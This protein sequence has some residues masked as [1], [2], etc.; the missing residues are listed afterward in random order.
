MGD[1]DAATPLPLVDTA[2][3]APFLPSSF[4]SPNIQLPI[5]KLE[6]HNYLDW[7]W[8]MKLILR[9][10]GKMGYINGSIQAPLPTEQGYP[11]WDSENSLVMAWLLFSMKPEI[12]RRFMGKKTAKDIWDSVAHIFD[13]VGDS[14]KVSFFF[15]FVLLFS[16]SSSS[17]SHQ[18]IINSTSEFQGYTAISEFRLFNRRTLFEC[19]DPNPFLEFNISAGSRSGLSDNE[20]V[21]VTVSGVLDPTNSDWVAMISPSS[22]SVKGCPL[23]EAFYIQTGDVSKLPLLCHYPVKAQFLSNDPDYLGCK[24]Q[25][26]KRYTKGICVL[27]TCVGSVTFHVINIRTAIEFVLFTGGFENPCIFRRTG[28]VN[29][30]NPKSPLYGH[31]SSIDSTGESMRLTWVSGEQ[32]PQ[33]VQYGDGKFQSSEVTTFTQKDMCSSNTLEPDREIEVDSS[34]HLT[35]GGQDQ[36]AGLVIEADEVD[37]EAIGADATQDEAVESQG[38]TDH[39]SEETKFDE[40]VAQSEGANAVSNVLTESDLAHLRKKFRIPY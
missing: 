23:S 28:S 6:N 14:T 11:K 5:A 29:F 30:A 27:K 24:K 25:E 37:V 20:N 4:E 16:S 35:L 10:R 32:Q 22:A 17:S 9:C 8:S 26:C 34:A 7:S 38:S 18:I 31:L 13:R 1:K 2:Q 36:I 19:L 3:T 33:Q 40:K 12:G 15:L 39:D 21:T